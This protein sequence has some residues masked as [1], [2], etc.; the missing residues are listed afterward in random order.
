ML[1]FIIGVMLSLQDEQCTRAA[2]ATRR[3]EESIEAE[4]DEEIA[5]ISSQ[6]E[7]GDQGDSAHGV[8]G[9]HDPPRP[10]SWDGELSDNDDAIIIVRKTF[11]LR[12]EFVILVD[13]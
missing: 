6:G 5:R 3:M 1:R 10:M 2:G 13:F 11:Q 7:G 9:R 8:G 12:F 4:C